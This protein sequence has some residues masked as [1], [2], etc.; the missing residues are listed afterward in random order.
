MLTGQVG[1]RLIS[2]LFNYPTDSS[3]AIEDLKAFAANY[4]RTYGSG[5]TPAGVELSITKSSDNE[6]DTLGYRNLESDDK[7]LRPIS[8]LFAHAEPIAEEFVQGSSSAQLSDDMDVDDTNSNTNIFDSSPIDLT[9]SDEEGTTIPPAIVNSV[10]S[11]ALIPHPI[12]GRG[13]KN[14]LV[15]YRSH[16]YLRK[17]RLG[18]LNKRKV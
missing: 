16:P 8:A 17:P 12:H 2:V 15:R 18:C 10:E 11:R 6:S 9:N 1:K 4:D 14:A 13:A 3:S 5:K 7:N